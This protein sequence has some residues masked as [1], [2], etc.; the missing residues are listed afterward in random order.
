MTAAEYAAAAV[1]CFTFALGAFAGHAV[2]Y[3]KGLRS[4]A[5][6]RARK[7]HADVGAAE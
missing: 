7:S 2:G 5:P 3:G 4:R 1:A 6:R